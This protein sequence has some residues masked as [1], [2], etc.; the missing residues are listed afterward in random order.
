MP[1]IEYLEPFIPK[2]DPI[3]DGDV[4]LY[5]GET[6]YLL[7]V[8]STALS[9]ASPVFKE[10]L[11]TRPTV[12]ATPGPLFGELSLPHDNRN[13]MIWLCW[14]LHH[15]PVSE[16]K[17]PLALV[18]HIALLAHKYKC[19][20]ALKFWSLHTLRHWSLPSNPEVSPYEK[21]WIAYAL[22]NHEVFYAV[23][24]GCVYRLP[25]GSKPAI[26]IYS[27]LGPGMALLPDRLHSKPDSMEFLHLLLLY[28]WFF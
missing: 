10:K 9:L 28:S 7:K 11:V 8:S 13:A 23:S 26:D 16:D 14:F 17:L 4:R 12:S 1:S 19:T 15:R 6:G 2:G 18:G 21:L 25:R 22:D 20:V 5:I 3:P 27:S 24:R